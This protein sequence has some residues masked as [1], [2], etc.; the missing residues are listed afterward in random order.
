[1]LEPRVVVMDDVDV[2]EDGK[3]AHLAFDVVHINTVN[4]RK[5]FDGVLS[6]REGDGHNFWSSLRTTE[7]TIW[8]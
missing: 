1:M 2:V 3:T 6:E 7:Y 8:L 4:N 5:Q